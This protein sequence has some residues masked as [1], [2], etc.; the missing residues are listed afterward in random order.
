[1]KP[2]QYIKSKI[3]ESNKIYYWKPYIHGDRT[4]LHVGVNCVLN[5]CL[6]NTRSGHIY[7][8]N[9]VKI[10]HNVMILTGEHDYIKKDFPVVAEGKDIK[11][12]NNVWICAGSIIIG[13]VTIGNN[14][15]VA[16]GSVV[17][18][19]VAL[20][21]MVGGNPAKLIKELNA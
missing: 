13:G 15:I 1:M 14:S 2:L 3:K 8:G 5:N 12:G 21:T 20:A 16:A 10:S 18:K 9:N 6:F 7:L 17:T 4:R 11:V 19:D